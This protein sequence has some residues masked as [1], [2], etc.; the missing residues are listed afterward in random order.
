MTYVKYVGSRDQKG[1]IANAI[2]PLPGALPAPCTRSTALPGH[3]DVFLGRLVEPKLHQGLRIECQLVR[4][5]GCE[6]L[7]QIV[8][9]VDVTVGRMRVL[10]VAWLGPRRK[11]F[12]GCD[13]RGRT[14]HPVGGPGRGDA[15]ARRRGPR[16]P[17][18]PGEFY[19]C[20]NPDKPS[21]RPGRSLSSPP[22]PPTVRS[23]GEQYDSQARFRHRQCGHGHQP[24][25]RGG[26]QQDAACHDQ[27][28]ADAG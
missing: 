4:I 16:S 14:R 13:S 12:A 20:P 23:K 5:H 6:R 22:P 8:E 28:D 2:E 3:V 26:R 1:T 10:L 27:A 9:A 21:S 18:K 15:S 17:A 11:A 25:Y 19:T 24:G 7:A